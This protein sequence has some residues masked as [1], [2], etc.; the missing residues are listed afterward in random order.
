MNIFINISIWFVKYNIQINTPQQV[1]T[2][3]AKEDTTVV[4]EENRVFCQKALGHG[5]EPQ[6]CSQTGWEHQLSISKKKKKKTWSGLWPWP[7]DQLEACFEFIITALL[8][9]NRTLSLSAAALDGRHRDIKG[10][11]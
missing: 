6:R 1:T 7:S 11:Q 3:L 4:S 9:F 8:L 5:I 2:S 10:A